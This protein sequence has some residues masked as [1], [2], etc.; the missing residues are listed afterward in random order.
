[1]SEG[2]RSMRIA[3]LGGG[4]MGETLASGFLRY[5]TPAPVVVIAE[6]RAE[7]ADE[8]R[9]LHGV[10]IADTVD[11]VRG[12][13]VVVLAVKPQ[14]VAALL[15]EVGPAIA[16]GTL[17]IS[18]AAGIRT[19]TIEEQVP[20]GVD[21]VRAMPNTPAQ[22][23]P[24]GHGDQPRPALLDGGAGAVRAT[25]GVRGR[26]RSSSP[27]RSRTPSRRC[28]AAGRRTCSSWPRR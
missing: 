1:M 5:V 17:V 8:L 3:V 20:A 23:R 4:V 18:I 22:G 28:R 19:G 13:T 6:K 27:S 2:V 21:V 24:R 26:R 9:A 25:A 16:P 14:D 7:R 12:A 11:A 10:E 15:G